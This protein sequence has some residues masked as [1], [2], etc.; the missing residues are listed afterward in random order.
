MFLIGLNRILGSLIG[1]WVVW[2]VFGLFGWLLGGL[3]GFV[4]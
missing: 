3:A 1:F 2:L 4:F